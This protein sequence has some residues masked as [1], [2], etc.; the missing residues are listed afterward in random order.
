MWSREEA[1]I[2]RD[3]ATGWVYSARGVVQAKYTGHSADSVPMFGDWRA[4]P[5]KSAA[6]VVQVQPAVFFYDF[7]CSETGSSWKSSVSTAT[8]L[9]TGLKKPEQCAVPAM[10]LEH[11]LAICGGKATVVQTDIEGS[12]MQILA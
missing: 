8:V 12:E 11:A 1:V 9:R 10:T 4:L 6:T 3:D 2:H 5:A 7:D